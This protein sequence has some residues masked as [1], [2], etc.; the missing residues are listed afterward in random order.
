[1][2]SLM[3]NFCQNKGGSSGLLS[4]GR[5]LMFAKCTYSYVEEWHSAVK[6]HRWLAGVCTIREPGSMRKELP[7]PNQI[8]WVFI[9]DSATTTAC[10]TQKRIYARH[11]RT[12]ASFTGLY[13]IPSFTPLLVFLRRVCQA[14]LAGTKLVT[15]A[16]DGRDEW[17]AEGPT[18]AAS[19][20]M[21]Y[22]VPGSGQDLAPGA[23]VCEASCM[24]L[25]WQHLHSLGFDREVVDT[26]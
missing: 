3:F 25:K 22:V 9:L 24:V 20:Q 23:T 13:A 6:L 18:V 16:K 10:F 17:D 19:S 12:P 1:M 11:V 8:S 2:Y 14:T 26:E 5:I 4:G 7:G 15:E 21:G